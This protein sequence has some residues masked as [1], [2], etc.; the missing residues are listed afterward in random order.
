MNALKYDW[1]ETSII[2]ISSCFE[3]CGAEDFI[4]CAR[5]HAVLHPAKNEEI[6]GI[7][8]YQKLFM[9]V[10][11]LATLFFKRKLQHDM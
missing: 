7:V 11:Q 2:I 1:Y 5:D 9:S 10:S 3:A 8:P 6:Y 4:F